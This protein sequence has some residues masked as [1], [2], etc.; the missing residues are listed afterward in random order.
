[1]GFL[2]PRRV[3]L[4]LLL[5]LLN[6]SFANSIQLTLISQFIPLPGSPVIDAGKNSWCPAVDIN[7]MARPVDGDNNGSVICDI[8]A[9]EFKP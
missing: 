9:V 3:P 1:M 4:V 5:L 6:P 7:G 2:S 8:G